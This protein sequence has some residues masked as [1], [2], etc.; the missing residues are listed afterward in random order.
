MLPYSREVY[1]SLFGELN[2]RFTL[3]QVVALLLALCIA[4]LLLRPRRSQRRLLLV[5][6]G[7]LWAGTGYFWFYQTFGEINFLAS[8]YT[9]LA[10]VQA[11][12][13]AGAAALKRASEPVLGASRTPAAALLLLALAWPVIDLVSGPGWPLARL[14]G[15]HAVPLLLITYATLLCFRPVVA[16][17]LGIVPLLLS[18][19]SAYEAYVLVLPRDWLPLL[20]S[21]FAASLLIRRKATA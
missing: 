11:L 19:V 17:P 6:L 2:T 5:L 1:F 16:L 15:L 3:F 12:G 9:A 20:G 10:A 7:A 13:L 21:L 14:I 18:G 8:V 4:C